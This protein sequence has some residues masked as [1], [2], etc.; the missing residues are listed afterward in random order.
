[1]AYF[2]R[3][4]VE[5]NQ[6]NILQLQNIISDGITAEDFLNLVQYIASKKVK[7]SYNKE[8]K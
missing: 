5:N 6:M 8:K 4:H 3:T 1:M 7:M 2:K